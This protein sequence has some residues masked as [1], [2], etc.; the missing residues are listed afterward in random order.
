[1]HPVALA[2]RVLALHLLYCRTHELAPVPL[3][4]LLC[5]RATSRTKILRCLA[6][7][8]FSSALLAP[9][10]AAL[11]RTDSIRAR[12]DLVH[13]VLH[14]MQATLFRHPVQLLKTGS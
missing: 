14:S 2:R 12:K 9:T 1:M 10:G 7:I 6:E 5:S 13:L 8:K 4:F 11:A 3:P